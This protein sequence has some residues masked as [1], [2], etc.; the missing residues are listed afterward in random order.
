[1][2]QC[3]EESQAGCLPDEGG[4]SETRFYVSRR[5]AGTHFRRVDTQ[6]E[7]SET[8]SLKM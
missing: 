7:E 3:L 4:L 8:T 6:G 5:D 1:M 2:P